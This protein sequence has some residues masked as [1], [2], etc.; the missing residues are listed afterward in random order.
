[1]AADAPRIC[2]RDRADVGVS[3]TRVCGRTAGIQALAGTP[4][5]Q[6]Q[7]R[8]RRFGDGTDG[9]SMLDHIDH[10]SLALTT[11]PAGGFTHRLGPGAT[12]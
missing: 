12:P 2:C 11:V 3:A 1:V 8:R 9:K 4:C 5:P 10:A 6:D 7:R